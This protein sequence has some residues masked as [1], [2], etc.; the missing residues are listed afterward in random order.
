VYLDK[1]VE[2]D[3]TINFKPRDVVFVENNSQVLKDSNGNK[4]ENWT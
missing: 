2:E 3:G 4:I 1:L